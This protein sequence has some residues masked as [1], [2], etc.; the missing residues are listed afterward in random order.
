MQTGGSGLPDHLI[1][2]C[3]GASRRSFV[4][5]FA[6]LLC[7]V[8]LPQSELAVAAAR[9][10]RK[11]PRLH[12]QANF[13]GNCGESLAMLGAP[14]GPD[15]D[16]SDACL[17]CR[18]PQSVSVPPPSQPPRTP[19]TPHPREPLVLLPA[20]TGRLHPITQSAPLKARDQ[21]SCGSARQ[22]VM[23]ASLLA[24]A[25]RAWQRRTARQ[26]QARVARGGL[27]ARSPHWAFVLCRP[28][29]CVTTT[30]IDGQRLRTLQ[31]Q[32]RTVLRPMPTTRHLSAP[33]A[34]SKGSKAWT[35]QG[36]PALVPKSAFA[37]R[38]AHTLLRARLRWWR[39]ASAAAAAALAAPLQTVASRGR[40]RARARAW[41]Q[42]RGSAARW[43]HAAELARVAARVRA[44]RALRVWGGTAAALH[45]VWR[46]LE[47]LALR[48]GLA[49]WRR[50]MA[51]AARRPER[52][53]H[54]QALRRCAQSLDS[55]FWLTPTSPNKPAP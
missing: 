39:R 3:Y 41:S 44:A 45:A 32:G 52:I 15:D 18:S 51:H 13:L 20:R 19:P 36:V 7:K 47:A 16:A 1:T 22:A 29:S 54:L 14:L 35:A 26:I 34:A 2:T 23:W 24:M 46:R 21:L 28:L 9:T 37:Q 17:R 40:R 31:P 6:R 50:S 49:Q 43:M 8:S 55:C 25:L 12:P 33:H 42:W 11:F 4:V 5:A 30:A 27:P 48:S 53:R 38:S 10:P